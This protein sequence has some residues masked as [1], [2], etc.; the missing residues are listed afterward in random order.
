MYHFAPNVLHSAARVNFS[1]C[2]SVKASHP[3][4]LPQPANTPLWLPLTLRGPSTQREGPWQDQLCLTLLLLHHSL[5]WC[6][7]S[8]QLGF[9]ILPCSILPQS[10]CSCGTQ[11]RKFPLH[12]LTLPYPSDPRRA[13]PKSLSGSSY[14]INCFPCSSSSPLLY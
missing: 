14:S 3:P 8:G 12:Y 6:P 11:G 10:F 7:D 2:E 13:F 5:L 9:L 1:Q 4:W